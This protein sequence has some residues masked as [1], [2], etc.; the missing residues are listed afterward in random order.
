MKLRC[1]HFS[2]LFV[3]SPS[4][5]ADLG[6]GMGR[7]YCSHECTRSG[8]RTSEQTSVTAESVLPKPPPKNWVYDL[9]VQ[10]VPQPPRPGSACS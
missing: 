3:P 5:Q 2:K 6:Y 4:Q 8:K 7:H 10:M 9:H 1:D